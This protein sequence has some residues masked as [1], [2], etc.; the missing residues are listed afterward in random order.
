MVF[1]QRRATEQPSETKEA[2]LQSHFN[3][4]FTFFQELII[5]QKGF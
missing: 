2:C 3:S 4:Y 1:D 5:E